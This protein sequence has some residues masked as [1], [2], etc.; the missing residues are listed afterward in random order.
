MGKNYTR[1]LHTASRRGMAIVAS[2]GPVGMQNHLVVFAPR[3]FGDPQPWRPVSREFSHYRLSGRECHAMQ[4]CGLRLMSGVKATPCGKPI[5]H[6]DRGDSPHVPTYEAAAPMDR[7][8]S[9]ALTRSVE[10]HE[11]NGELYASDVTYLDA[12][13][14]AWTFT[15]RGDR[16]RCTDLM[17][18]PLAEVVGDY[19]PLEPLR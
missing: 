14:D 5:G 1:V 9:P 17:P 15:G 16:M 3:V 18:R 4:V 2:I 13:G 19:G 8:A 12:D 10:W 7:E 6:L 11:L